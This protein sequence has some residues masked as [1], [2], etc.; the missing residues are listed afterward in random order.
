MKGIFDVYILQPFDKKSIFELLMSV[1]THNFTVGSY[2]SK[3]DR[4][5]SENMYRSIKV[6]IFLQ[7]RIE[8][9]VYYGLIAFFKSNIKNSSIELTVCHKGQSTSM[10]VLVR[11][12][13]VPQ[14]W[15]KI[16]ILANNCQFGE[17]SPRTTVL[18][19]S[20]WRGSSMSVL[21]A[22]WL[23]YG[24][25]VQKIFEKNFKFRYQHIKNLRK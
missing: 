2:S 3:V 4:M 8:S 12:T 9:W 13:C 7:N 19:S 23:L 5:S 15:W 6:V 10:Y 25:F 1:H 22:H 20:F 14:L 11:C 18:N 16:A 24:I 17:K 21:Y